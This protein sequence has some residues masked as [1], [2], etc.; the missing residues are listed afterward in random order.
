MH[1][2]LGDQ[3][4]QTLG[5][6]AVNASLVFAILHQRAMMYNVIIVLIRLLCPI[7]GRYITNFKEKTDIHFLD[8]AISKKPG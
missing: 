6:H 1:Y 8:H 2:I 4:K 5:I 3:K 7:W